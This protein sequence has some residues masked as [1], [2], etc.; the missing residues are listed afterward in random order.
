MRRQSS[1]ILSALTAALLVCGTT[2]AFSQDTPPLEL[3]PMRQAKALTPKGLEL[4]KVLDQ[5]KARKDEWIA[6]C[7]KA[8]AA[9]DAE[10]RHRLWSEE[11]DGKETARNVWNMIRQDIRKPWVIPGVAWLIENPRELHKFPAPMPSQILESLL[12]SIEAYHVVSPDAKEICPSLAKLTNPRCKALLEKIFRVNTDPATKGYAALGI[13]IKIRTGGVTDDPESVKLRGGY[14]RYALENIVGE[15]FDGQFGD[16]K[17]ENVLREELY[18]L[19]K[20][21]QFQK[22]PHIKAATIDGEEF[23]T[24]KLDG[25][26]TIIL[27]WNPTDSAT[28]GIILPMELMYKK[29]APQGLKMA[30]VSPM[31]VAELKDIRQKNDITI[32]MISDPTGAIGL[33]YR[34][35]PQAE[36]VL[37]DKQGLIRFKQV[38]QTLMGLTPVTELLLKEKPGASL[39]PEIKAR[40]N[41]SPA[42]A[43]TTRQNV[44]R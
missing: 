40:T 18:I 4:K 36:A 8:D 23:D 7:V 2:T 6:A 31:P 27:F 32:P 14:I 22:P 25:K 24:D 12:D 37:L 1:H 44:P 41:I 3:P 38:V 33:D 13:A 5:W 9:G 21:T 35:T 17:L 20:L 28:Q 15:E 29:Y 39:P 26:V 34:V 19:N 16:Q 11:P 10:L 43:G 30:V 42:A